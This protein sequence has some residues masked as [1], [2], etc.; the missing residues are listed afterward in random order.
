MI[1]GRELEESTTKNARIGFSTKEFEVNTQQVLAISDPFV[2][3]PILAF[4][5]VDSSRKEIV[6][7]ATA[8]FLAFQLRNTKVVLIPV[9]RVSRIRCYYCY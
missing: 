4:F 6:A 2:L 3:N 5:V 9:F 7:G 8:T 1:V